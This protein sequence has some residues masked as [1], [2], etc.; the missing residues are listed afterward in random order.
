MSRVERNS[1]HRWAG[2]PV[3]WFVHVDA[4]GVPDFRVVNTAKM[5]RADRYRLCMLCGEPLGAYNAFVIGPMCAVNRV[6]SEPP[7]HRE[8]C[9]YAV[10]TCPFLSD[11]D[12]PRRDGFKEPVVSAA[13]LGIQ[14]NPGVSAVW[15]TKTSTRFHV[16]MGHDGY[17]WRLG[18]PTS[19]SW[20]CRGRQATRDE[21]MASIN[22]G[23]PSL[24]E[25]ADKEGRDAQLALR[26][27]YRTA[28]GLIP[29]D[30]EV[31]AAA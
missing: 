20:W 15:S 11:P 28:L 30:T 29:L 18:E 16:D 31:T 2:Y 4:R 5:M 7:S 22:T 25:L 14:R 6:S 23:M 13:G 12:R 21:V 3:P 27:A 19:I 24:E 26:G 8:C 9:E 10:R 1:V 17:L